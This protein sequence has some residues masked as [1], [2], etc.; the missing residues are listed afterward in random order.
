MRTL[1][2]AGGGRRRDEPIAAEGPIAGERPNVGAERGDLFGTAPILTDRLLLRPVTNRD[3]PELAEVFVS[4]AAELRLC[5]LPRIDDAEAAT[6]YVAGERARE[7]GR[8]L[9]LVDRSSGSVIGLVSLL[10]PNPADGVPWIGLLVV[11]A[12]RQGRGLG[13]EAVAA[14]ESALVRGG[15]DAVCLSVVASNERGRRFWERLG[16]R[17]IPDAWHACNGHR[18]V[19][20]VMRHAIG[21]GAAAD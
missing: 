14:L 18:P 10:V 1:R 9:A 7:H 17:E 16:Y 13:G 5:G 12:D 19:E 21:R 4:N 2:T 3:A 8:C 20:I 6:R 15:W 11:A